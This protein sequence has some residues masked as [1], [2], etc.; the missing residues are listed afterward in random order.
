MPC[1]QRAAAPIGAQ[2]TRPVVLPP[3]GSEEQS[4]PRQ[5]ACTPARAGY[6]A[7][8]RDESLAAHGAADKLTR[9][10]LDFTFH[11]FGCLVNDKV[12]RVAAACNSSERSQ[13][14]RQAGRIQC[15]ANKCCSASKQA[16]RQA[17]RL[18][19]SNLHASPQAPCCWLFDV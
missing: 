7:D 4:S 11:D 13:A 5:R 17:G 9:V 6:V 10:P 8:L 16:G 14:G 12:G 18:P 3:Q 2:A 19:L 15:P 1:S